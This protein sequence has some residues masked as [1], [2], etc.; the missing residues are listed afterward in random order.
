MQT[1]VVTGWGDEGEPQL[2]CRV[3][4]AIG[5]RPLSHGAVVP[6][7]SAGLA[8]DEQLLCLMTMRYGDAARRIGFADF[9]YCMLRLEIMTCESRHQGLGSGRD[10]AA[11]ELAKPD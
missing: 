10:V 9:V 6:L 7:P 5:A 11:G 4:K 2:L 8:T 3:H 1:P